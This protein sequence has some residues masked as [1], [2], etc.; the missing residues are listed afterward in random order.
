MSVYLSLLL[1]VKVSF[2]E[3]IFQRPIFFQNKPFLNTVNSC[4]LRLLAFPEVLELNKAIGE[5]RDCHF[6]VLTATLKR[7]NDTSKKTVP[8]LLSVTDTFTPLL[9]CSKLQVPV[10]RGKSE[11]ARCRCRGGK[12]RSGRDKPM[13]ECYI[14][15]TLIQVLESQ[16][17]QAFHF[18]IS[19]YITSHHNQ[20][21]NTNKT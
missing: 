7:L 18:P 19:H 10:L 4:R 2:L 8:V 3:P 17:G 11:V 14:A 1:P 9:C 13:T 15:H 12:F 6:R 5:I 16:T 21:D 20:I